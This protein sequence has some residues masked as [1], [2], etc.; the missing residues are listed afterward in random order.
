MLLNCDRECRVGRAV[1]APPRRDLPR[2]RG[3]AGLFTCPRLD[4]VRTSRP[5]GNRCS[6]WAVT[7]VDA[8]ACV[9]SRSA[10]GQ[11]TC[12]GAIPVPIGAL[13][14]SWRPCNR[15]CAVP[16]AGGRL[17]RPGAADPGPCPSPCHCFTTFSDEE[18]QCRIRFYSLEL[19]RY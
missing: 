16:A 13:L 10:R 6:V 4:H 8:L 14:W 19:R 3:W 15:A 11:A 5:G 1:A 12:A 2:G 9:V 17:V 18:I 7:A